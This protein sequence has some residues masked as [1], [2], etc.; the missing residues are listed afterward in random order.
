MLGAVFVLHNRHHFADARGLFDQIDFI[1]ERMAFDFGGG[2]AVIGFIPRLLHVKID[3]R[4]R[5]R[6]CRRCRAFCSPSDMVVQVP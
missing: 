2:E 5:P 1:G 6:R 3:F 4:T